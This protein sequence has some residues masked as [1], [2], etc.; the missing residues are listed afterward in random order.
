MIT[1]SL[2]S[3]VA[4]ALAAA[5]TGCTV[6]PDRDPPRV[7]DIPLPAVA[8][9]MAPAYGKTL[10][11]DTPQAT[12]PFDSSRILSKPTAS[13]YRMYGKVRWRDTAPVLVRELMIGILRQDGRFEGVINETSPGASDL[14]LTSDLSGFHSEA[15]DGGTTVEITLYS[16]L[17]D[18]RSRQTLCTENFRISVPA[19]GGDID[20]VV[21]TF[22]QAGDQLSQEMRRWLSNCLN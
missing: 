7:M 6:F 16:Q 21:A 3:P 10:R 1:C 15:R 14:T 20:D 5:L 8:E 13:E 19:P 18:N 9:A 4:F 17:M 2:R 12:E 11:V 22:A